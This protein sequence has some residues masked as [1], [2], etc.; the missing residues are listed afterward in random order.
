MW[1][2]LLMGIMEMTT[3]VMPMSQRAGWGHHVMEVRCVCSPSLV[4]TMLSIIPDWWAALH[5]TLTFYFSQWQLF[6]DINDVGKLLQTCCFDRRN[7]FFFLWGYIFKQ[8]NPAVQYV[9]LGV[10][11]LKSSECAVTEWHPRLEWGHPADIEMK[12][13]IRHDVLGE[14]HPF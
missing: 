3:N 5:F 12:C 11:C 4:E 14:K 2:W 6:W 9:T 8:R 7:T 13:N 1:N 10:H